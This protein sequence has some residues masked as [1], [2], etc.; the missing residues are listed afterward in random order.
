MKLKWSSA[1]LPSSAKET[2]LDW[3]QVHQ[4]DLPWRQNRSPYRVWVSEIMLQQTQVVTV[5]PYFERFLEALPSVHSLAVADQDQLMALWSGLGYYSRAR[6]LQLCAQTLVHDYDGTLPPDPKLLAALPGFGAYTTAAVGSLAFGLDLAVLDGNVMRVLARLFLIDD[7]IDR[8]PVRKALQLLADGQLVQGKA[9][10]WNEA[11]MELGATICLPRNPNCPSC[12]LRD[13][14]LAHQADCAGDLPRKRGKKEKPVRRVSVAFIEDHEGRLL[15]RRREK[16]GFLGGLWELPS[17]GLPGSIADK[18]KDHHAELEE[19]GGV[20]LK[21]N[22]AF[23]SFSH[24]YSHFTAAIESRIFRVKETGGWPE[25]DDQ[26]W[27]NPSAHEELGFSAS[28]R[29]LLIAWCD[30]CVESEEPSS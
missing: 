11:M 30:K 19:A 1:T 6:R 17:R 15:V 21:G 16:D 26:M 8:G 24:H 14:C 9:G 20:S 29:K 18:A 23:L 5:I 27:I 13:V 22:R 12:V 2:L 4:R 7:E 28:D 25:S 3:F 10:Q